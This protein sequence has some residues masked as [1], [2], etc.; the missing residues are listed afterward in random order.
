MD[1][2]RR[3]RAWRSV[4][5]ANKRELCDLQDG[6]EYVALGIYLVLYN[7]RIEGAGEAG[8]CA[9]HRGM[10]ARAWE[11]LRNADAATSKFSLIRNATSYCG[12]EIG[13]CMVAKRNVQEQSGLACLA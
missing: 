1:S 3:R 8:S 10:F 12:K 9:T 13:P 6:L 5:D 4:R 7:G 2:A 11:G